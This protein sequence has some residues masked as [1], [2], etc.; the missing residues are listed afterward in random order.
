MKGKART[1]RR[2]L[3]CIVAMSC[4]AAV[5]QE[6]ARELGTIGPPPRKNPERQTAA[7]G[8]PPLPVTVTPLRRSEPKAEPQGPLFAGKLSYAAPPVLRH[9]LVTSFTAES[10]G[11]LTDHIVEKLFEVLGEPIA[12]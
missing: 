9:R 5:A 11:V 3:A 8:M 6:A 4:F 12:T 1:P 2:C 7:E 10:D